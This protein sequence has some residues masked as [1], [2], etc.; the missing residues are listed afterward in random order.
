MF[1]AGALFFAIPYWAIE[2]WLWLSVNTF[3]VRRCCFWDRTYCAWVCACAAFIIERSRHGYGCL[4]ILSLSAVAA[5]ETGHTALGYALVRL[6]FF[7]RSNLRS[8]R[9]CCP[10]WYFPFVKRRYLIFRLRILHFFDKFRDFSNILPRFVHYFALPNAHHC[11]KDRFCI[12]IFCV[13]FL[14]GV[15][16]VLVVCLFFP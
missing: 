11:V 3:V 5:F 10:N 15:I 14:C 13:S 6:S 1:V 4:W 8:S 12:Y 16:S 7:G 9:V 2:T